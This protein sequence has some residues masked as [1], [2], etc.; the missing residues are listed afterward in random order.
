[1][2]QGK[3]TYLAAGGA[4]AATT[5]AVLS[6]NMTWQQGLVAGLLALSQI[7]LRRSIPSQ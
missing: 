3:R 7:F 5:G 4:I 6:G 1:M 2:L